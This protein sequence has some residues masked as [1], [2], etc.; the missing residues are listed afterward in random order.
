LRTLGI[1]GWALLLQKVASSGTQQAN[2]KNFERIKVRPR[3]EKKTVGQGP[4]EE[5]VK[6][7][8]WSVTYTQITDSI[9]LCQ[10][11]NTRRTG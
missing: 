6:A 3:F 2:P 9:G 7:K 11:P 10:P 8:C 5:C 1:R 4:L